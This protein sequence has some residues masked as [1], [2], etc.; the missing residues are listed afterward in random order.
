MSCTTADK[1]LLQLSLAKKFIRAFEQDDP[2]YLVENETFYSQI[3][4]ASRQYHHDKQI[5]VDVRLP[6]RRLILE[7]TDDGLCSF[8]GMM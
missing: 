5:V 3:R 8:D 7:S 1:L 6:N 4:D 2:V